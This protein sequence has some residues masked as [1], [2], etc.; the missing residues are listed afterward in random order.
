MP[1]RKKHIGSISPFIQSM[2]RFLFLST[3]E[4][5]NVTAMLA[6]PVVPEDYPPHAGIPLSYCHVG[7]TV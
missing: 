3:L 7:T 1:V 2:H 5:P 4:V 6:M